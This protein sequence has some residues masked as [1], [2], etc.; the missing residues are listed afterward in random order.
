MNIYFCG[1]GGVGLGP[2]AEIALDAGHTVQGSDP[3]ESLITRQ[4]S[5]RGVAINNKQKGAF[6]QAVHQ[7]TPVDWFVYT[8]AT[9]S[10]HPELQLAKMLGIKTTKRDELLKYIIAEKNLKLI[11]VAGSHGKTTTTAM[12]V[13]AFRE[14]GIPVSYSVGTTMSFGPSGHYEPGSD[15]FVYECDEF[16][17]NFLQFTPYVSIV[18]SIDYDHPDTYSTPEDYLAAFR[19]F[20]E[21]SEHMIL[22]EHDASLIGT[23]QNSWTLGEHDIA[24]VQL[25]GQHNRLNASLVAKMIEH[26]SLPGDA[27]AALSTFPGV[28]RRFE[29]IATNLYSDYGHHPTEIA[30]TLQLARELADDVVLVYQPHQNIRQHELRTQYDDCF[31][32]A[33]EV[34]WLPTYLTREDPALPILSPQELAEYI[35]NYDAVRFAD[36]NDALWENIQKARDRGALVLVMG[37]GSIDGW[38]REKAGTRHVASII[39]L[40]SEGNFILQQR[41]T[42]ENISSSGKIATFGGSVEPEDISLREAAARELREET[43]IEFEPEDLAFFKLRFVTDENDQPSIRAYY[44]LTNVET[45]VLEVYEGQGFIKVNPNELNKYP[46]SLNTRTAIT[47]YIHPAMV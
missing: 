45:D 43:N 14:L 33:S 32:A 19:Q 11:A 2:L 15:Y 13:W 6:L 46:L 25:A 41:D 31:E 36:L 8:S 38:L 20:A 26:I 30:A 23:P 44:V 27:A 10:D 22:W 47:E 9:P 21:Q 40:D 35:T 18:T 5:E 24:N 7:H 42:D 16:D 28:D 37:A 3:A 12:T 17:R 4:L 1:I 39:L 34:Y 29:K